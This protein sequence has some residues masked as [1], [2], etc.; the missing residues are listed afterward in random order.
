MTQEIRQVE[1]RKPKTATDIVG[2]AL[3]TCGV[4]FI[5][6]APGTWGSAVG[7]AVYLLWQEA[8]AVALGSA[9]N[10]GVPTLESLAVNGAGFAAVCV[11]G[12]WAAGRCAEVMGTKDPQKVVV[13]EVMGQLTVF[14]FIPFGSSWQ[15]ILAGFLLFR[16]FDI[17]KPYPIRRMESLPAGLG[18]CADDLLA[19]VYGGIS[20]ALLQMFLLP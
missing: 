4:G 14:L 19:G 20:L 6:L 16:L 9:H 1:S 10:G 13:D 7:V 11:A 8:M 3:A 2:I 18:I 5:P 12:I 17:W 15:T